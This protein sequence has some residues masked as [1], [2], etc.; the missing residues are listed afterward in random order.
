[1]NNLRKIATV[2]VFAL[3]AA[4]LMALLIP[5]SAQ[6][7]SPAPVG[8]AAAQSMNAFALD[9]Y[10]QIRKPE[11]NLVFSPYSVSMALAMAYAGA[12][13]NTEAQMAKAM[14][15]SIPQQKAP[16]TFAAINAQVLAAG[17]DK[18]VEINVA[19]ALWAEKSYPFLKEYLDS[20][21]TNYQ[22]EVRNMDFRQQPEAA[23]KTI[24]KW[25]EEQTKDKI[26]DFLAP[27]TIAPDTRLVLTN[28]IYFKG[29][30]QSPFEREATKED[31]FYLLDG[32]KTIVP[33]MRQR[34][35][36][37]Y[38]EEA[39]LQILEML[40]KGPP[41]APLD[42]DLSMIVLLPSKEKPLEDFERSITEEKLN[43]WTLNLKTQKVLVFLPRFKMTS[44]F[45]LREP[46]T[47]LGMTEAFSSG[48]ADLSGMTG[49]RDLFIGEAI[50]KAFVETNEEGT[51]AAAAT[52]LGV[53]NGTGMKT[54]QPPVPIFR[55]D[56]PFVFLIRH[57]PSGCLLFLGRVTN[58]AAVSH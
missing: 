42:G 10:G 45:Q 34:S 27:G 50:H 24:N 48:D 52:A 54:R 13:G 55:A 4:L 12:R 39:G 1:M 28:A 3:F 15:L 44:D 51:E 14:H 21:R 19:N 22:G 30:W 43:Q 56:H 5:V 35:T 20:V 16:E 23:R 18:S 38:S 29:R 2:G 11:G 9:L 7:E 32:A 58:P 41:E 37:G 17:K 53:R 25:V 47:R 31:P 26:K 57:K 36:F 46:L 33:M 6:C 49:D 8:E 40:Y